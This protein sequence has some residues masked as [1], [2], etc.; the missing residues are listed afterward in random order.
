[1]LQTPVPIPER[2]RWSQLHHLQLGRYA[3]YLVK[4]EFVLL[5]CDVF[6]SEVD[7]RGIDFVV[8]TQ[9]ANH[10]D[11]QVKSYRMTGRNTP[12][13]FMQK[14]KFVVRPSLLLA[15]VQFV[16]GEA[17]PTLFLIRSLENDAPS[18]VLESRDYG[19]GRKSPPEW[20]LTMSRRKL[21]VLLKDHSFRSVALSLL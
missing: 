12:Y 15:L 2:Y 7:N 5:G 3:E 18:P 6:S 21:E 19:E 11:I 13:V 1:M 10:F 8:R 20:G 17:A 4:M 14:S 9:D 16:D